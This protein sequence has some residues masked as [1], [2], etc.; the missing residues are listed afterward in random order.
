MHPDARMGPVGHRFKL[1][2]RGR[3][4]E[5][6]VAVEVRQV[7]EWGA[8]EPARELV[9]YRTDVGRGR[10]AGEPV[11]VVTE[12]DLARFQQPRLTGDELG[13]RSLDRLAVDVA[14]PGRGED[15]EVGPEI[16]QDPAP[17][18]RGVLVQDGTVG[19][20]EQVHERAAVALRAL[21]RQ[22]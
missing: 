16:A 9:S 5:D 13:E 6:A 1:P 8:G 14:A 4:G 21:A 10:E 12:H 2:S 7:G 17:V 3:S 19:G 15:R 20:F 18:T 11:V 22:M